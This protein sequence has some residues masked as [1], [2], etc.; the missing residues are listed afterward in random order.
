MSIQPRIGFSALPV[1]INQAPFAAARAGSAQTP[2]IRSQKVV[3]IPITFGGSNTVKIMSYNVENFFDNIKDPNLKV[4]DL[5]WAKSIKSIKALAE[6]I[7]LESPDIIAMQ[8]VENE[9]VLKD[10]NKDHLNN[11]YPNYV[12]YPT[13]D[14]RGIRVAFMFKNSVKLVESVSHRD[15]KLNGQKV[16]A[17]D[18]LEA[19]FETPNG[20]H[21]TLY[22][23]H[24]K[25][26]RGGEKE[27]TQRRI[28]EASTAKRLIEEKIAKNPDV[29][30]MLLGDLNTLHSQH[31]NRVLEKLTDRRDP[32]P[33]N[34]MVEVLEQNGKI[35]NTHE[36]NKR[37]RDSKL[38]YCFV[39]PNLAQTTKAYV[40]GQ[41]R[42]E[43]WTKASDHLPI[44][45]IVEDKP[46]ATNAGATPIQF[47]GN[48]NVQQ[49]PQKRIQ[50]MA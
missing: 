39:T 35:P 20:N 40:A 22:T 13:N 11:E 32:N 26:M 48:T 42:K 4:N 6:A 10:F 7:K 19:T 25:S 5:Q 1:K 50:L 28:D 46:K 27:T 18:L 37:N 30:I 45:A 23:S 41:F 43:P 3:R 33:N 36:G 31:G 8:E 12:M 2:D 9:G 47:A 16:F 49:L 29:K 21:I 15:E 44:V 17:R 14:G 24:F 38:D 34:Q